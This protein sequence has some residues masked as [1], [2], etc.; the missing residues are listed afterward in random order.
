MIVHIQ[1]AKSPKQAWDTL[2]K[3]YS[4]NTQA[5]KMQL[6]QGLH[7]LQKNKMNINDYSTKVKNLV[8]V[9][10][11]IGAPVHDEDLVAVT[12]NGLGKDYSQFCTSITVQET[13]PN[14]QDLITLL[15]SEEMRIVGT[16]SNGG[17]QES[18]FYS[19]TNRGRG[20]GG[21]T[22]FRGRP[23]SSHGGHQQHEGQAHGGGRGNFGGR[24]SRE[25]RGG[26]GGSHRGQQPNSE[27]NC[28]YC[29][30]PGH[31]AKNCYQREHDAR[32]G[33]LQQG[34]N[35]STSNQGDEQLFVMQ[36][37]ANSMIGGVSDNNVWYVDSG[38]SNH[39]TNHG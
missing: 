19:N 25:S 37:M 35:A 14:F 4:T 15:I 39:M 9:L 17:S 10:A 34:N 6:K 21:K 32:N 2:V 38:A 16:S 8:D 24:G 22:S 28:F 5:R 1:D 33:K 20:R 12:L 26:H 29:G 23:G 7:N 36:H 31:M 27:S 11:S 13:F 30:K 3:M 18:V